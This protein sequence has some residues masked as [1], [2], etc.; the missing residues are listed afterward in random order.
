MN[1]QSEK[2]RDSLHLRRKRRGKS[3]LSNLVRS[4]APDKGEIYFDGKKVALT[5]VL[6]H[7]GSGIQT[8]YQE[9]TLFP[10]LNCG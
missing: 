5:P 9:H 2:G 8:I 4:Y 6:R 3:T 10:L 1:F 7:A